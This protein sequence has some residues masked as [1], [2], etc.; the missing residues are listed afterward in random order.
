MVAGPNGS[1]KTSAVRILKEMGHYFPNYL[2][3]DDLARGSELGP[4]DS[5][6]EAQ[7][8]VRTTKEALLHNRESITYETVMS[9]ESHVAF[10]RRARKAGYFVRLIFVTTDDPAINVQ[11]VAN[12]VAQGGHSVPNNKIVQRY[13]R[14]MSEQLLPALLT[15]NEALLY[16]TTYLN[17]G[18]QVV[19]HVRGKHVR[20]HAYKGLA[21]PKTYFLDQLST[22]A[23]YVVVY[24]D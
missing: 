8:T 3:A 18:T 1:G 13:H 19:A 9:H 6:R 5:A 15:A 12:R 20:V 4:V 21:W 16:D 22:D 14:V 23:E 10:M 24:D 17:L 11:R 7:A 2:N